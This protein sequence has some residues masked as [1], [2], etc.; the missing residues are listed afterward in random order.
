M[1]SVWSTMN[2]CVAWVGWAASLCAAWLALGHARAEPLPSWWTW[3][4]ESTTSEELPSLGTLFLTERPAP[5]F[6]FHWSEID[7]P[8]EIGDE[9]HDDWSALG[10][11]RGDD[12]RRKASSRLEADGVRFDSH[13]T[14]DDPNHTHPHQC[15]TGRTWQTE[16]S[17]RIGLYGPLFVFGQADA[18]SQSIERQRLSMTGRTGVGMR[19]EPWTKAEVQVRGGPLVRYADSDGNPEEEARLALELTARA[20]IVGGLKLEYAGTALPAMSTAIREQLRQDVRLALHL[21]ETSQ[22]HVGTQYSW[23][24][25]GEADLTPWTDRMQLYFGMQWKR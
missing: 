3:P 19:W 12:L 17:V 15:P 25:T 5:T 16:E 23:Q 9:P 18:G 20:P 8:E 7:L 11:R 14:V 21:S 6:Q 13:V 4:T 10:F 2:G 22:F 24:D 1:R